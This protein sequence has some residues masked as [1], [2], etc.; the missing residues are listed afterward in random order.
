MNLK[1]RRDERGY[2]TIMVA[3]F[4]SASLMALCAI[5]VD[6]AQW[7]V[8]GE[9]VQKAVDAAA[10]AGVP[11]MPDHLTDAAAAAVTVLNMNGYDL[12][13]PTCASNECT[14]TG[15]D[16]SATIEPGTLTSQL[17]VTLTSKI[18][19]TFGS[20]FGVSHAA[21]T[22]S[23]TSD[24]T[25]VTPMGSPCNAFGNEPAGTT[26]TG[27]V[28]DS[29]V[30]VA[31]AGGA[32]CSRTP[33]FWAA[34][35]GPN[36][37]KSNGDQVMTRCQGG[38]AAVTGAC[39]TSGTSANADF[40]PQGY[41]YVIP[42]TA[43][44]V[45]TDITI[46]LF[47][48]VFAHVGDKCTGP[49][50]TT[51][52]AL[53]DN[54]NPF[55]RADGLTRYASGSTSSFCTG[56]NEN[57]DIAAQDI[58]T[59]FALRLP[60]ASYDPKQSSVAS[61]TSGAHCVKQFPSWK[62]DAQVATGPLKEGASSYDAKLASSFRQ[63]VDLCT[64]RPTTAGDYYLQIRTNVALGGSVDT[65]TGI[66]SGNDAVWQQTTDD[67]SVQGSGNNR[68]AIRLKSTAAG[69][70]SIAGRQRMS[71]YVNY[72][73][74][75]GAIFNLARVIPAAATKSLVVGFYDLGDASSAGTIQILPPLDSGLSTAS[76]CTFVGVPS[77][78]PT[79]ASTCSI[80]NVKNTSGWDGSYVEIRIPIPPT[81]TCTS[82]EP[83]GCWWRVELDFSGSVPN[84]TTTWT[85]SISGDPVR[86]IE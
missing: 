56:D 8:E 69:T 63:W 23:A 45:G 59:S 16:L 11:F 20:S 60:T 42:V 15:T 58:I 35:A 28:D 39:T 30:I 52:V 67:T 77:A 14:A 31:P 24:F 75:G 81:Y 44:A 26:S 86:L 12:D 78:S 71:L 72:N 64:F 33:Q 25:G 3:V 66:Y 80:T 49:A 43:D 51:G 21:I 74:T 41:F 84:D 46:Q 55:V 53:A 34:I 48:P 70:I 62:K 83:G 54:M 10:L 5:S 1:S 13:A 40:D 6:T 38:Y 47:D 9:R 2:V 18:G 29:S 68:F 61:D 76:D 79:S 27:L 4:I 65:A 37:N 19:N 7:S 17:K 85:A 73:G 32:S 50:T 22:R 57:S 82:T 36:T